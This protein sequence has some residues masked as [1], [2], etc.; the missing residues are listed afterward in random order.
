MPI[1][2][3]FEASK[4]ILAEIRKGNIIDVPIIALDSS[5][6]HKSSSKFKKCGISDKLNKPLI[7]SDLIKIFR[8][9]FLRKYS[10]G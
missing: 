3:G 2:N 10:V 6:E 9:Y 5:N 7:E 8:K 1:L 4:Q